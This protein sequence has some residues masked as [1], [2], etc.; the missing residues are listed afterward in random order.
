MRQR[1]DAG[2][3][4]VILNQRKIVEKMFRN[5]TDK[6]W[7]TLGKTNPYYGV[8]T[9]DKFRNN[10]L[11][12]DARAE[13]FKSGK[14]HVVDLLNRVEEKFGKIPRGNAL[15][16]G[17]GVGRLTLPLAIDGGF[18]RVVGMDISL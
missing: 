13:F 17:C 16:F 7:E 6:S 14:K 4:A 10:N 9:S 5:N 8:L 2:L 1:N 15:D 18:S 11:D 12:D 3:R